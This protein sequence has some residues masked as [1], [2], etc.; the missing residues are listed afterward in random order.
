MFNVSRE[1]PSEILAEMTTVIVSAAV[2]H[3]LFSCPTEY[4]KRS[5]MKEPLVSPASTRGKAKRVRPSKARWDVPRQSAVVVLITGCCAVVPLAKTGE[6]V[7]VYKCRRVAGCHRRESDF[8]DAGV[9][10]HE[11]FGVWTRE[12][13]RGVVVYR[14][15]NL[16]CFFSAGFKIWNE[17]SR[18]SSTLIIAPALSN[19]PQ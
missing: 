19:S 3:V 6:W 8:E 13:N 17:H 18:L 5:R 7:L 16:F 1:R 12:G 9:D 4:S 11:G 10:S 14:R 15:P 2:S